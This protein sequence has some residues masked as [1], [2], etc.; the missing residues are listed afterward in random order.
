MNDLH[1]DEFYFTAAE[2]LRGLYAAFP[3][4]RMLLVEDI[5]GPIK[6]DMTGLPDRKSSACFEAIVWLGEHGL[7]T[8]RSV[9]PRDIGVEGAV[10]TQRAFVLLTSPITWADGDTATRIEALREAAK[11]MAY[12]NLGKVVNDVLRA[13][14]FWGA[15]APVMPFEKA[16]AMQLEEEPISPPAK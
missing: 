2:I 1:I 15:P 5:S 16:P 7:L 9:E 6:W 10:L 8:Y 12:E 11:S 13:N 14:C 3:T 4:R